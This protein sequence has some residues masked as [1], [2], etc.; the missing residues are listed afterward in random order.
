MNTD[1]KI[2]HAKTALGLIA[3][4]GE[5]GNQ[6]TRELRTC[7]LALRALMEI[8]GTED[9]RDILRATLDI[10]CATMGG[11]AWNDAHY[12]RAEALEKLLESDLEES[13]AKWHQP[14][15]DR[16]RGF[17]YGAPV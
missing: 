11:E 6:W 10:S 15:Y 2:N 5:G 4:N 8:P 16:E 9:I 14:G 13:K 12:R 1:D 3:N 7:R 17:D